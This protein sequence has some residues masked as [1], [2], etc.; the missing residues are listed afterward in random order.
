MLDM[1]DPKL[2]PIAKKYN[3]IVLA[4]ITRH[5]K[6]ILQQMDNDPQYQSGEHDAPTIPLFDNFLTGLEEKIKREVNS[7]GFVNGAASE[8]VT[9]YKAA[10]YYSALSNLSAHYAMHGQRFKIV[11]GVMQSF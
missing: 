2:K 3:A 6:Q 11:N 7:A 8:L 4:F 10:F 5:A 9:H 1:Q